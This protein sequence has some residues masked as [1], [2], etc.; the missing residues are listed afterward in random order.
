MTDFETT[1]YISNPRGS[2][3]SESVVYNNI[4][5]VLHNGIPLLISSRQ[6]GKQNV[7][8]GL[9][10]KIELLYGSFLFM[11]KS[12]PCCS[13]YPYSFSA[14]AMH[15]KTYGNLRLNEIIAS[16][17]KA[18]DG[19][20]VLPCLQPAKLNSIQ[21]Q[22]PSEHINQ[23]RLEDAYVDLSHSPRIPFMELIEQ[24]KLQYDIS[25]TP[26]NPKFV[27]SVYEKLNASSRY[28]QIAIHYFIN[29]SRLWDEHFLEDAGLNLNLVLEA[30]VKDFMV[31]NSIKDKKSAIEIMKDTIELPDYHME[32]IE[33]LYWARN[34]FL[35]HIDDHMFTEMQNINDPDRYCYEHYESISWLLHRYL[36]IKDAEQT[37]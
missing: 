10:K 17:K 18:I 34:E 19:K 25:D 8:W 20:I 33:E 36:N 9:D 7:A 16:S 27:S 12:F 35:A 5:Y 28:I 26:I 3:P 14:A 32:F 37:H 15:F 29:A 11:E 31:E 21:K 13:F 4:A 24:L 30:V 2:Y 23:V 6:L 1:V 22:N